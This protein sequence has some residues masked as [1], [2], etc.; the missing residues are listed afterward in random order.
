MPRT[1]LPYEINPPRQPNPLPKRNCPSLRSRL[2]RRKRR[3]RPRHACRRNRRTDRRH[4]FQYWREHKTRR[5]RNDGTKIPKSMGHGLSRRFPRCEG[6]GARHGPA[7]SRD[8]NIYGCHGES[9]RWERFCGF[10]GGEARVA[11]AC[12]EY[13]AGVGSRGYTRLSRCDRRGRGYSVGAGDIRGGRC[14]GFG[15]EGWVVEARGRGGELCLALEAEEEC[16]D[17]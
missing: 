3:H 13:G 2:P 12:G 4:R 8:D 5:F 15:G 14:E 7:P 11:R 10:C 16:V 6:I 1:P 17:F 9:A